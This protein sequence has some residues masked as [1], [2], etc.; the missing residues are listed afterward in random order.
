MDAYDKLTQ[1]IG[2]YIV[3]ALFFIGGVVGLAIGLTENQETGVEQSPWFVNGG[4]ILTLMGL[5]MGLHI[6]GVFKKKI[7]LVF[8]PVLLGL[9]GWFIYMN[10]MSIKERIDL[11]N[12][13]EL[14]DDYVKQA[15]LDIRDIQVAFK[16]T[17]YRYSDDPGELES[18]LKSGYVNYVTNLCDE[19]VAP[20]R[21][22]TFEEADS[23]GIDPNTDEGNR[24]M[25]RIDEDEAVRLDSITRDTIQIPAIDYIFN[26][27]EITEC[28]V[29]DSNG[30]KTGE[31]YKVTVSPMSNPDKR[32]YAFDP[33]LIWK[34][35]LKDGQ[36]AIKADNLGDS[37]KS[38]P[39]FLVYDPDPFDPFMDRDTL[40]VGSLS[41]HNTE[42]NWR[43]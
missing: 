3:P 30:R 5:L 12:E 17:Y 7:G 2:K 9:C 33:G 13:K 14:Y 19:R 38:K 25:E 21:R 20:D 35:R 43:D 26:G 34:K 40:K 32:T 36:Y 8:I 6:A 1:G 27:Y 39:V 24:A 10:Y 22:M 23:L 37:A 41:K 42:G 11:G 31:K 16:K 18:F 28:A 15:L 29:K 4:L